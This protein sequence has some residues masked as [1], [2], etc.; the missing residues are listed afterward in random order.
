VDFNDFVLLARNYGHALSTW[1]LQAA[2][3]APAS[4]AVFP[5]ASASGQSADAPQF[6]G[7]KR[8]AW[9]DRSGRGLPWGRVL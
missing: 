5:G 7:R 8:H 4:P 9:R 6:A 2:A 3:A 1:P